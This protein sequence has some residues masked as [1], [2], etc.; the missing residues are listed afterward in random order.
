MSIP[1]GDRAEQ[2]RSN[3]RLALPVQAY[4]R[5]FHTR[6]QAGLHP[7]GETEVWL[8]RDAQCGAL[9]R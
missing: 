9:R 6:R 8:C 1:E 5:A 3:V 4:M 7:A 2:R